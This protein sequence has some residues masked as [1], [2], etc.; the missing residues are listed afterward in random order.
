MLDALRTALPLE[1]QDTFN[2]KPNK[3]TTRFESL[4][5]VLMEASTVGMRPGRLSSLRNFNFNIELIDVSDKNPII[6]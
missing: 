4:L 1:V 2:S 6:F 5:F 3:V